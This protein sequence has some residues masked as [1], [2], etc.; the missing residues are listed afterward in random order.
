MKAFLSMGGYGQY[1][2]PAYCIAISV[3]LGHVVYL[4]YQR[5]K[6]TRLLADWHN[7]AKA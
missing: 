6:V 3:F 7:K 2:W 1:V 5:K 4:K